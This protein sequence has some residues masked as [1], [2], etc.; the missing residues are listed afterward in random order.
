MMPIIP[1]FDQDLLKETQ[2]MQEIIEWCV[3]SPFY[4]VKPAPKKD[5]ERYSDIYNVPDAP[6]DPLESLLAGTFV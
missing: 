4:P 3:Q 2:H 5:L 6:K 1:T